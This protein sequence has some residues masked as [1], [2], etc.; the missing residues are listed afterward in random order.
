MLAT[1]DLTPFRG[2]GGGLGATV[3][4]SRWLGGPTGYLGR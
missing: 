3:S 2:P 1:T 4:L